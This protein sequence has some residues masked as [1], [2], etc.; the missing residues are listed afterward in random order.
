ML[1]TTKLI[2]VRRKCTKLIPIKYQ[3]LKK[4]KTQSTGIDWIIPAKRLDWNI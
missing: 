2:D 4:K 1:V 3:N